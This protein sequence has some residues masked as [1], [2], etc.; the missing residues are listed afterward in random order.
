MPNAN[1]FTLDEINQILEQLDAHPGAR[2]QYIGSRYQPIFGRK[3]QDSIEWDNSGTY[4][5]LTIVLYH[6]NSY[7]SR[8][9]VPANIEITDQDYWANTGNYNAQIEQYRQEVSQFAGNIEANKEAIA[10]A[11]SAIGNEVQARQQADTAINEAISNEVQ[12]RQQADTAVNEAIAK[13]AGKPVAVN[14]YSNTSVNSTFVQAVDGELEIKSRAKAGVNSVFPQQNR[15]PLPVF[16]IANGYRNAKT[17]KYGNEYTAM[18]V[19]STY[20]GWE[21]ARNHPD[22]DGKFHIDCATFALLVMCGIRFNGSTYSSSGT[23]T[24]NSYPIN[25]FSDVAKDYMGYEFQLTNADPETEPEHRRIL[26]SEL[27]KMLDDAGELNHLLKGLSAAGTRTVLHPGDIVFLSNASEETHYMGIGHC[28]VV[29]YNDFANCIVIDSSANRGGVNGTVNYHLLSDTELSQIHCRVAC[30]DYETIFTDQQM[31]GPFPGQLTAETPAVQS[32]PLGGVACVKATESGSTTFTFEITFPDPVG[33]ITYS[34]TLTQNQVQQIILPP[35]TS[36][37]T[38]AS[39][40]AKYTHWISN[41]YM[42]SYVI[43]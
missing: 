18:N 20:D 32:Y 38:T 2:L 29:A 17:I 36:I 13:K 41:S 21:P 22:A 1:A 16:W 7:T 26:T 11:N 42:G 27:A 43:D 33:K 24:G 6:G 25:F 9:F 37:R 5:P 40:Q 39:L 15:N 23:N 35:G 31:L 3:G 10:A 8:Q 4:E 19:N 14:G 30:P 12:A 34:E 28:A